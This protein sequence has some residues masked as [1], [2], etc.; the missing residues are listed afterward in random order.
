M[1]IGIASVRGAFLILL[2]SK[3]V[4]AKAWKAHK[5]GMGVFALPLAGWDRWNT[6]M[7]EMGAI[8]GA[9]PCAIEAAKRR[10]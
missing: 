3:G 10:I 5:E 6:C 4:N 2:C 7:I 1:C 8:V 9:E